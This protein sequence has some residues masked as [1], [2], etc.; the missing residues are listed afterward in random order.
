MLIA[1]SIIGGFL[2]LTLGAEA[3]VRG[4]TTIAL[5]LGITPLVIGLTIVA[6]GTSAPELAVSVK[7]ALAGNSG[8]A[9]GN[10]IGSN[11]VNIGLILGI[12]AL[13]RPIEVKSEM[14]KRDIPIMILASMLFWGLLLDGELSLIDGVILLSFMLGYL[15]FS[16]FSAKNTND[17]DGEVIEEGPKNPLLSLLFIAVGISMLVGGGILFV[18][19]AVDLAKVFGVS[20]IIIG[21][22][23]VAIGTS[24]PELVTSVLAALKGQSDIAIGNIVGS[25]IF[26]ILGILGVTAIVYP[27]SGLGFQSLDFIVMLAFAVVI[28]PFAWTGLRIGRREGATLLIAYLGYLIYLVNQASTQAVV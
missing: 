11:I 6:F 1:L 26:N 27:V 12:T 4:A 8:I 20:E 22:T 10:V 5:R 23:I 19:G 21:L 15:V 18:N 14:V 3:L 9:L 17:A 25:N 2:I 16:Y 28:L 13:I 24:M 7:A